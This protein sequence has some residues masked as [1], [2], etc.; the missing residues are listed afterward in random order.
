MFVPSRNGSQNC[1]LPSVVDYGGKTFC[2]SHSKTSQALKFKQSHEKQLKEQEE[3][4]EREKEERL[5][6]EEQRIQQEREA[7]RMKKEAEEKRLEEMKKNLEAK[8]AK[9]MEEQERLARKMAELETL[10]IF[11][12]K[13]EVV[14]VGPSLHINAWGR[15]EDPESNFVFKQKKC[16]GRQLENGRVASLTEKDIK[17]LRKNRVPYVGDSDDEESASEESEVEVEDEEEEALEEEEA[18]EAYTSE[19]EALED[20]EEALEEEE[21]EEPE[22]DAESEDRE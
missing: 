17:I 5:K 9:M 19:E 6:A 15:Y 16:Y 22:S 3:S 8:E 13:E 7:D 12:F 4:Q 11:K 2:K 10:K 18:E 1:T 14:S 20:E 21:E